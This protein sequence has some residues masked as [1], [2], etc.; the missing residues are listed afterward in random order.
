MKVSVTECCRVTAEHA[1]REGEGDRS[2]AYWRA[3]H[4]PFLTRELA[5]AGR[6]FDEHAKV[7]CEEFEVVYRPSDGPKG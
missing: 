3:V 5:S 2:L 6:V 4:E 1:F 7:V